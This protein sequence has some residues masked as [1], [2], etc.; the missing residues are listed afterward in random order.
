MGAIAPGGVKVLDHRLIE[1]LDLTEQQLAEA[2]A[3]EEIELHRREQLYQ[4]ARPAIDIKDKVVVLVDDG[5]AT[6]ASMLVAI[7]VVRSMQPEK[8]VV[9]VPVAPPHAEH[10]IDKVADEFVCLLVTPHFQ[11]VGAFYR[12]FTQTSDEEVRTLL[13]HAAKVPMT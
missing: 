2:I 12:D 6:G 13:M 9:A 10:E 3:A 4:T 8:I 7:G 5:V 1:T 11:A